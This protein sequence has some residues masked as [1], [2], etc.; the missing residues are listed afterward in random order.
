MKIG[1]DSLPPDVSELQ[2]LILYFEDFSYA[3]FHCQTFICSQL[4]FV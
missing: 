1:S 4:V 2:T 3:V